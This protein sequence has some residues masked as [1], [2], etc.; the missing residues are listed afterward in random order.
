MRPTSRAAIRLKLVLLLS[1]LLASTSPVP[2]SSGRYTIMVFGDSLSAAFGMAPE[3]G[4]VALLG[5]RLEGRGIE[6]VNRSISGETTAGGLRRLPDVLADV[7]PDLVVIEL[8]ANDG[9]RGLDVD[10]MRT[11]LARMIELS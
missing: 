11:N 7:E 3:D 2:G 4:W 9:L 1:L 10:A 6:V 8:G 5:N